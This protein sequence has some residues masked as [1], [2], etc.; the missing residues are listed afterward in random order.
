[1]WHVTFHSGEHAKVAIKGLVNGDA[2]PLAQLCR[3]NFILERGLIVRHSGENRVEGNLKAV[4]QSA[5][6]CV[7]EPLDLRWLQIGKELLVTSRIRAD[8]T[9]G[10][11]NEIGVPEV[12]Q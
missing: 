11:R 2:R 7:V 3:L 1:M 5:L 6:D 12:S 9:E 10:R 8:G 4:V